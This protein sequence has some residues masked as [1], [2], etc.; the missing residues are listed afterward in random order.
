MSKTEKKEILK[1]I[2]QQEMSEKIKKLIERHAKV[3]A[4]L[5]EL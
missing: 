3:Y 4:R 1:E 2:D 5:A